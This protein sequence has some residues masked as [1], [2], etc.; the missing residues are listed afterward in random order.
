MNAHRD[1]E[2]GFSG[3]HEFPVLVILAPEGLDDA[4]A[5]ERLGEDDHQVADV[6]LLIGN[7]LA[8]PFS[9]ELDRDKADGEEDETDEG[10][11]PVEVEKGDDGGEDRDRLDDDVATDGREGALGLNGVVE[12]VLEELTGLRT[13]EEAHRLVDDALEDVVAQVIE[14]SKADPG[15]AVRVQESERASDNHE[16]RDERARPENGLDRHPACGCGRCFVDAFRDD[17]SAAPERLVGDVLDDQPVQAVD[18]TRAHTAQEACGEAHP[19]WL[20]V[21]KELLVGAGGLLE[22]F[23]NFWFLFFWRVLG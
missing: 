3:V 16:Y 19:V 9:E 21:G 20:H 1:P 5:I 4:N 12:D 11:P 2:R 7:L 6:V 14:H 10:E 15:D 18:Q 23:D 17:G 8:D 22:Q 13:V